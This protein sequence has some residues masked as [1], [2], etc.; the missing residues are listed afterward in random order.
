MRNSKQSGRAGQEYPPQEA[1]SSGQRWKP[2][3]RFELILGSHECNKAKE[4]SGH[5][6]LRYLHR[7]RIQLEI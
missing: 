1:L 5:A 2:Q 3:S 7:H 6:R 4:V